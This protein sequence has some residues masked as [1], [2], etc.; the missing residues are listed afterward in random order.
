MNSSNQSGRAIPMLQRG[1]RHLVV[2]SDSEKYS[3]SPAVTMWNE[4]AFELEENP[5]KNSGN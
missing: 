5:E 2:L 1:D 4:L 3:M